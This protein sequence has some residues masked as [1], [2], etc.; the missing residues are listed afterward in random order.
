MDLVTASFDIESCHL[1]LTHRYLK[2]REIWYILFNSSLV[3]ALMENRNFVLDIYNFH[4][5]R[6]SS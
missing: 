5:N 4:C 1:N 6:S 3:A 2:H